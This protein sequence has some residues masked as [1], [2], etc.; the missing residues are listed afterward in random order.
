MGI[1]CDF[2]KFIIRIPYNFCYHPGIETA[3]VSAINLINRFP[4]C[5]PLTS[6]QGRRNL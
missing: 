6:A 4:F 5:Y 3:T 2:Y 1:I